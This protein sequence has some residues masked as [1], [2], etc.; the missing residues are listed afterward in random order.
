VSRLLADWDDDMA[1]AICTPNVAM[2]V[3]YDRRRQTLEA[4]IAQVGADRSAP[5]VQ[6]LSNT[7]THLRWWLPGT[8][9]RLRVE[10]RLAPLAAGRVQ[11]LTVTAEPAERT[12]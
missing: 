5:P 3:P 8:S 12:A 11:T 4:A 10:I 1:D 2:D 7:P 6:E 9:G